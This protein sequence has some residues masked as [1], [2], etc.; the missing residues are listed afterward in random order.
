VL[1]NHLCGVASEEEDDSEEH[2]DGV[3]RCTLDEDPDDAHQ[4]HPAYHCDTDPLDLLVLH[5]DLVGD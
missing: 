4:V 5:P 3:Q 2:L 1:E